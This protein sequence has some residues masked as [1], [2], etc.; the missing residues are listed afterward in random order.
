DTGDD[1]DADDDQ[2]RL[3]GGAV[4]EAHGFD[5]AVALQVADTDIEAHVDAVVPVQ[6]GEDGTD[7]RAEDALQRRGERVDQRDLGADPAGGGGDLA[8]DPARADDGHVVDAAQAF[9]EVAAVVEGAQRQYA[10][11]VGAARQ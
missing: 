4:A 10:V 8:A 5:V 3:H 2:F 11:E 6:V 7:V 1:A 9:A